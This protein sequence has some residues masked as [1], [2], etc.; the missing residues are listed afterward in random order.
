[1]HFDAE[2]NFT[3]PKGDF[4]S[5]LN[6]PT[7]YMDPCTLYVNC[8]SGILVSH[9]LRIVPELLCEEPDSMKPRV[10]YE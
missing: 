3:R 1:M 9:N 2:Q 6:R 4:R 8:Y 5:Y 7:G 10:L